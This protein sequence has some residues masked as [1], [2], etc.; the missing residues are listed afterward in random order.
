MRRKKVLIVDD[1]EAI[2][3]GL[4]RILYQENPRWDVL[5]A[6]DAEIAQCL[7]R[8]NEIDVMVADIQLPGM[9]GLDLMCWAASESPETRV[10]VMTAFDVHGLQDRAF[11]FGCLRIVQKPFDLH[12][13]KELIASAMER[14]DAVVG[15]LSAF[16]PA[17]VIQMLCLSH[18]TTALRVTHG[19]S[20]GILHIEDGEIVHAAWD[21]RFGEEAVFAILRATG[22]TFSTVPLPSNAPRSI[23]CGWQQLLLEGMRREDEEARAAPA[24]APRSEAPPATMAPRVADGEVRTAA[25]S[26]RVVMPRE[27]DRRGLPKSA[28]VAALIDLGFRAL[29]EGDREAARTVWQE[30]LRL[31]PANR[32]IELNLRKLDLIG[33]QT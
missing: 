19:G 31:D 24:S 1:E 14:R 30:A 5:P 13:M 16:S 6:K 11:R 27:E 4:L 2:V 26:R 20:Y 10:I 12:E 3:M 22:G 28:E 23:D 33:P 25:P 32:M 15:S 9:S 18:K 21:D 29:R 7:L 8:E 17:D